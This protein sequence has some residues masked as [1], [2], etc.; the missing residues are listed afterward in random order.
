M[1][2]LSKQALV[3]DNNQS[4]PNNN[5]GAITP[6][7]LRAFNT[8]MIDS[9]V[10][11]TQYTTDSGSWNAQIDALE[12]F[13][14]SAS[15]VTASSLITASFNNGTRNLTFTKGNGTQFAVNI[16]DVSGSTFNTA[17]FA[18]TGSNTFV[19][20]QNISGSIFFPNGAQLK[21]NA[22]SAT[23]L[24]SNITALT[25]GSVVNTNITG[26]SVTINNVDF[27]PFS[28]S[29]N[30]RIN[31]TGSFVT[32]S[33][34]NAYTASQSTGSLLLTASV[35]LNT[36]TFTKADGTTFPITVNTGSGG[37][38]GTISV[39]DEGSI[40]GTATSFNFTGAGVTATLS[41][42]TASV[43]IPGGGGSIDT[44]SFATTGSNVFTGDQTLIDPA[45]NSVALSDASGS[46]VLVAKSYTSSSYSFISSSANQT[47]LMFKFS[48]NTA[49]TIISGSGNIFSNQTAPA[50][51]FKK[52]IGGN[53][54]IFS[55]VASVPSITASMAFSPSMAANYLAGTMTMRGPVSSSLWSIT[56]N[57][58]AGT[59]TIG[60]AEPNSATKLTSGL[61]MAGN[62][63][64]GTV[65]INANQSFLTGSTTTLNSNNINGTVTLQLS[66]SALTFTG[67]TINDTGFTLTNQFSSSSLGLGLPTANAN[68]IAGASNTFL[69]TGSQL[70]SSLNFGMSFNQ[71]F[72]FGQANTLFANASNSRVSGSNN[73][74]NAF[75]TGLLGQRLIVTGSSNT[76]DAN[77][78]GSV[79]VGRNN[80]NDGIRN[81]TSDIV[82]AVGTGISSSADT[83]KT[84]FL[85]DSGSNSYFEGSLNVSGSTTMTGSL[86][87]APT[88]QIK[89][90]TGSNQQAD[91][92]TLNGAN[93]GTVTVSNSLVTANSIIL[94]SKQTLNHPQGYVAV[95]AK[96]AGSFTITSN[97]NGDTD[98]VGYFIINNS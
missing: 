85:I 65:T 70:T 54:N 84:G 96:S 46:L 80:A 40:L 49:D 33:S 68:T 41:A 35:N 11:Q 76:N 47:N 93:P 2:E 59:L 64:A 94:V 58:I 9:T 18:T 42:G 21:G 23:E 75:S 63:I 53:T 79:F 25:L 38:G 26:S 14:A 87:I 48:N 66:S 22:A 52:Y 60:A 1:S 20:N 56:Q 73:Y 88:F 91:V 39:Q 7:V 89:F 32:T 34:F 8:N 5:N 36:I 55:G 95:S 90:A 31:N 74:S 77:S 57:I 45:G 4:F 27:I 43:T 71:N 30:T 50:A 3:V 51:G 24:Y 44:G 19:G 12:A 17:S 78:F 69:M 29:L 86:S 13:T 37:G 6:S 72:V 81:K 15:A 62:N 83:R 97:H 28:S 98:T 82:F 67:N 92:A 16:P 10:N 61:S